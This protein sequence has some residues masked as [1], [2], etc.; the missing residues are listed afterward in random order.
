MNEYIYVT[1]HYPNGKSSMLSVP[2]DSDLFKINHLY[3]YVFG[4]I[5]KQTIVSEITEDLSEVWLEYAS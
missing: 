5:E 2:K 3:L 4:L 1:I